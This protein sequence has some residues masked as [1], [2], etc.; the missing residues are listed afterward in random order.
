[1]LSILIHMSNQITC[2]AT[3]NDKERGTNKWTVQIFKKI[4]IIQ[5]EMFNVCKSC[6]QVWVKLEIIS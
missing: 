1:M 2:E 3:M 6:F 5:W 4:L